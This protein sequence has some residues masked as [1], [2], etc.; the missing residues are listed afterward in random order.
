MNEPAQLDGPAHQLREWA[1]VLTGDAKNGS[2]S[3]EFAYEAIAPVY[4]NFTAHHD[5]ELWLG[6]LLP[7]LEAHGLS[8]RRLLDVG[9]GT[10]KSFLPMLDRGWE[11]TACDLSPSMVQ[12]AQNKVGDQ[13]RVARADMRDL[14]VFGEFDVVWCLDDAI[15]YLLSAEELERSLAGMRNNL[16]REGLLLFD[17]NTLA[18]YRAFFATEAVLEREGIR[19]IWTG[20]TSQNAEP[21]SFAE[22]VFSAELIDGTSAAP[23]VM[24]HV[25]RERHFSKAEVLITL[26]R[27]GL[28]CL[29]IYGHHEDAVLMQPL[30]ELAHTKAIYLA[31]ADPSS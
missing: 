1:T 19:M 26:E 8:G 12:I 2:Y 22:A 29:A 24:P 18:T 11:V 4:D 20:L 25:H 30:D 3:A 31:R 13:A 27:A 7:K 6:N 5:Y 17:C 28:D 21:G 14:P 10:G 16:A 9:C 23:L 15:N